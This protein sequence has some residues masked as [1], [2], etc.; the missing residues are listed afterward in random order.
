DQGKLFPALDDMP[1]AVKELKDAGVSTQDAL[2][3]WQQGFGYVQEK[4]RPTEL[5]EDVEATFIHYI[6]EKIHLLKRRQASDKVENSTGFLLEALKKNYTNPEF[7]KEQ[8]AQDRKAKA[9][10]LAALE[11][12]KQQTRYTQE[13][14][15]HEHCTR[16]IEASPALLEEA[17][18]ALRE[19][20]S[21]FWPGYSPDQDPLKDYRE[22]PSLYV[23]IEDFLRQR[24]PEHFQA[25]TATYDVQVAAL[26]EQIAALEAEPAT[27]EAE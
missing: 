22:R 17:V 2:E 27:V 23:P 4:V 15:L 19:K 20:H 9:R 14:T 5:G 13:D 6:R 1:P 21:T 25:L 24:Y 11:E 18:T 8:N 10:Q 7:T 12:Q 26:A 3:I 16:L